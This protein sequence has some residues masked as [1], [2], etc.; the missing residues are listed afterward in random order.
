MAREAAV[1]AE[2]GGEHRRDCRLYHERNPEAAG[3]VRASIY[4]CL[5]NL[6]L[7]PLIG[8]EQHEHAVRKLVTPRF[9]YLVYYTV[10]EATAEIVILSFKHPTQERGYDDA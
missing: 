1:Y 9:G 4:D 7:F 3:R 10:D 8:R 5:Q 6:L 2:G